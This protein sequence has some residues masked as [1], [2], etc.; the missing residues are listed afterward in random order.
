M[1]LEFVPMHARHPVDGSGYWIAT[2]SEEV[3]GV[4]PGAGNNPLD[5]ITDLTGRLERKLAEA[6]R[7]VK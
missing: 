7:E 4:I 2:P 1:K 3:V 6:Q 5:A